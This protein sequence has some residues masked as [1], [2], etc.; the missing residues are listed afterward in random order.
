MI[1][2]PAAHSLFQRRIYGTLGLSL[3]IGL[4]LLVGL[5]AHD[6]WRGDDARYFGPV[7]GL[8]RGEG[9]LFPMLAGEALPDYPPLYFWVASLF[10]MA[11]N[12]L[13]ELH[14]GA[15]LASTFFVVLA[16]YFTAR[17]A[18]ALYGRPSRTP[19]ALLALG[20]L[21]L[22]L[23][24]HETQPLLAVFAML[25]LTLSGLAE[26]PRN[27]ILG[28]LQAGLGSALAFLAGGLSGLL[29]TAPLFPLVMLLCADC[30]TP[31]ASGALLLG[32]CMAL[33]LAAVW[34]L[35]LHLRAPELFSLWSSS[36]WARLSSTH[37]AVEELPRLFEL[38]GW[39]TWPLWPIAL[40]ALWRGRR[41][42]SELR[43]Q[44]PLLSGVL[45]LG[46]II[47]RGDLSQSNALPLVPAVAL[48]AAAGVPT[49]RRGA[50]NAFD[51]FALMSLACVGILVW[52]A[53]M[54]QA[55]G[56]PPGL[57]RHVARNA[58][59]FVLPDGQIRL[60]V[61]ALITVL[62]IVLLWRLPRSI[63]RAPANWAIGL[64]MLWC[65]SVVLLM[66]WFDHGRSYRPMA[67]SLKLA[68][69][70]ER[71]EQPGECVASTPLSDSIRS[72]LDYFADLRTS[73]IEGGATPCP[74][75]L[76]YGERRSDVLDLAPEWKTVWEFSRGGGRRQETF[77]LLRRE[78]GA[79]A[80]GEVTLSPP[81]RN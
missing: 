19:A 31:R 38:V 32:L 33:L 57:A 40:W 1:H 73:T 17:T 20:A 28:S 7:L 30:R 68:V 50:A 18:E 61:G 22:V 48:L 35:V 42:L 60:I 69:A 49:L 67:E 51:W 55:F 9:W 21:G 64:T 65:L 45:V 66:P 77:R 59:D 63:S 81:A 72:S 34:P 44:L 71:A 70:G 15:R 8:V 76:V 39:F 78:A 10:A 52:L 56:W 6:P 46:W 14:G 24:A 27:P 4:Y 11:S 25:A 58:P 37:L 16:I 54:A 3:L 29:L 12:G 5:T 13:L 47:L 2:T 62:W 75:L 74:L 43:W 41:K 26:V 23:H 80:T 53:W 79:P 36:E